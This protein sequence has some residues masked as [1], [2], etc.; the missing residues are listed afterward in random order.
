MTR[1]VFAS[2]AA[3][4]IFLVAQDGAALAGVQEWIKSFFGKEEH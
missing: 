4:A 3:I 1:K 2:V